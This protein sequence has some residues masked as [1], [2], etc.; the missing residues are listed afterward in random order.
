MGQAYYILAH[1]PASFTITG[2]PVDPEASVAVEPGW[3]LVPYHG[4]GTVPM[5]EAFSAGGE[6]VVMARATGDAVYYPAEAVTSF[7]HAEPGRGYLVYVTESGLLRLSS[8]P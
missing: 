1:A 8:A 6:A 3:N 4:A 7:S 2:A 5:D